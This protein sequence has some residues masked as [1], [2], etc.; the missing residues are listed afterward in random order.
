MSKHYV[1]RLSI[2]RMVSYRRAKCMVDNRDEHVPFFLDGA[3][4]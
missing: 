2:S 1:E 3:H 4:H